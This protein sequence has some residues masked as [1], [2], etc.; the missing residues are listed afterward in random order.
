MLEETEDNSHLKTPPRSLSR[1]PRVP[2]F[3]RGSRRGKT[4]HRF[5]TWLW[6]VRLSRPKRSRKSCYSEKAKVQVDRARGKPPSQRNRRG[7]DPRPPRT[8]PPLV[9]DSRGPHR[10]RTGHDRHG[11]GNYRNALPRSCAP[12]EP[13]DGAGKGVVI[14]TPWG[15]DAPKGARRAS[16]ANAISGSFCVWLWGHP[17]PLW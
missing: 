13:V 14:I 7:Y 2:I 3:Q 17:L 15:S 6:T 5:P 12:S 1:I 10:Q 11:D 4:Q 9:Q 8:F 16:R